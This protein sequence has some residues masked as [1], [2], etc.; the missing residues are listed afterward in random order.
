M[1]KA[2]AHYRVCYETKKNRMSVASDIRLN[3]PLKTRA[4]HTLVKGPLS[5]F[6]VTLRMRRVPATNL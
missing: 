2:V 3:N 5:D 4:I 1:V 6:T